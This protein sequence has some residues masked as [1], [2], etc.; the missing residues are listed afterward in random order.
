MVKA[1][2]KADRDGV[3]DGGKGNRMGV[4]KAKDKADG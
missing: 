4:R 1:K 3:W 2:V